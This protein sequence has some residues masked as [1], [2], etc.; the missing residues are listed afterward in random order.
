MASDETWA[1][2]AVGLDGLASG[3]A[4]GGVAVGAA[5]GKVALGA[6]LNDVDG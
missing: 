1:D 2:C 5:T 4:G 3:R 6:S